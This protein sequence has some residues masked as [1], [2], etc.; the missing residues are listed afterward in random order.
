MIHLLFTIYTGRHILYAAVFG[1]IAFMINHIYLDISLSQIQVFL[2]VA[3]CKSF[4][5]AAQQLNLTQSAVSKTIASMERILSISLFERKKTLE[6]TPG[7][8]LLCAEWKNAIVT[9]EHS[10]ERAVLANDQ[11]MQVLTIGV[12][13]GIDLNLFK[14]ALDRFQERYPHVFLQFERL[15]LNDLQVGLKTGILDSIIG[16]SMANDTLQDMDIQYAKISHSKNYVV[17]MHKNNPMA[18]KE[19]V[20]LYDLRDEEFFAITPVKFPLYTKRIYQ[21]C[22]TLGFTPRIVSTFPN[23]KSMMTTLV[24]TGKGVVVTSQFGNDF[25]N[26]KLKSFELDNTDDSIIVAWIENNRNKKP[27]LDQFVKEMVTYYENK[28]S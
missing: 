19:K 11:G 21:M 23:M 25:R 10:I 20:S 13:D 6:L 1:E 14:P 7:G 17:I 9:I 22:Q 8:K 16:L 24:L 26:P 2:T 4:T 15:N 3:E 27:I 12:L 28:M 5:V 18:S